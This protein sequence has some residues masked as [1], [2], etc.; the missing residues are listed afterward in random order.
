LHTREI[1]GV[2]VA[3]SISGARTEPKV[4]Q[5]EIRLRVG[6]G[7][8]GDSHGGLGPREVSLLGIEAFEE[9]KRAHGTE[10]APGSFAENITTRGVD[11]VSLPIGTRLAVG[12]AVLEVVEIG[13][14]PE[15]AHTYSFKGH[16]LLPTKGIFCRVVRGG[17]LRPGDSIRAV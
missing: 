5:Q 6:Y 10:A 8:E 1:E 17:M 4:P 11:L 3:V 12:E 16:S 14:P 13:K 2:V 7:V 15:A 9:L